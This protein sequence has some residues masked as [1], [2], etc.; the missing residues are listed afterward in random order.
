LDCLFNKKYIEIEKYVKLTDCIDKHKIK[1]YKLVEKELA[2]ITDDTKKYV[3]QA[4]SNS[5]LELQYELPK[6]IERWF[7]LADDFTILFNINHK[8]SSSPIPTVFKKISDISLGQ[9]V[10]AILTFVFTYGEHVNDNTPL[11]IDQP[12][13]NLDNQ[14]IFKNLVKSLRLIKNKRQVIIVTHSSTIV[15]NADAEQVLI[16]ESD[17]QHGWVH[18]CGYPRDR[19]II[20]HIINYLEGGLPSFKNK[21]DTY[22]IFVNEL[23]K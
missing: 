4:I 5:I 10:V 8:E 1:T 17:N 11:I 16:M 20:S 23:A 22:E 15:T 7:T 3:Y 12:E 6:S 2:D 9:K 13:D 14:Y 21:M 18:A 19:S